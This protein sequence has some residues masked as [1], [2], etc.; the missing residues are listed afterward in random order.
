MT[1][2][3]GTREPDPELTGAAAPAGPH[4]LTV[5]FPL[6]P[7]S[8]CGV[9]FECDVCLDGVNC[10][11]C[12]D[13]LCVD[14]V[15][16]TPRMAHLLEIGLS[17]IADH[18][19]GDAES[20]GDAPVCDDGTWD[21]FDQLPAITWGMNQSWRRRFVKA[22][23]DLLGDIERGERPRPRT[24]A[25]EMALFLAVDDVKAH[26]LDV[27]IEIFPEHDAL[28][29]TTYDNDWEVLEDF[30]FEDS[31]ILFLYDPETVE[32]ADPAHPTNRQFAIGDLR[33]VGWFDYFANVEPRATR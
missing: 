21:F 22:A 5:L 29:V 1:D 18:A 15:E 32:F 33:P 16:F 14:P 26:G 8:V 4:P 6:T 28:P 17:W 2:A 25:E 19:R 3:G 27:I 20:R 23:E 11:Q 30:L 7:S 31:D 12:M 9:D 13:C 24:N 10:D